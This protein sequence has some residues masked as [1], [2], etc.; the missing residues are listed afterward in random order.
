MNKQQIRKLRRLFEII[1]VG[2]DLDHASRAYDYV[3]AF[4]IIINL[5]VSVLYTF[6]EIRLQFGT[7][8]LVLEGLTV[9]FFTIDYVLRI[10]TARFLYPELT[11]AHAIRL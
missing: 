6:S 7:I 2:N 1:E 4:T 3:N 8:L 10:I 5:V 9:V 11:D